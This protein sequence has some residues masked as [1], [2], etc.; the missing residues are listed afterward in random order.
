MALRD[1]AGLEA[2]IAGLV[3]DALSEACQPGLRRAVVLKATRLS[4]RTANPLV[5]LELVKAL[6]R[7]ERP[8]SLDE[9]QGLI[10]RLLAGR[11]RSY[12]VGRL[13]QG[14][15]AAAADRGG[16]P[17]LTPGE[18][19]RELGVSPKTVSNWCKQG[20]LACELLG[21]GHRRIPASALDAYRAS[22]ARWQQV[23]AARGAGPSPNDEA[24]FAELTARRR[25]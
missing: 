16:G 4:R 19:A 10:D 17:M 2:V 18:V 15:Q 9:L 8:A 20:L 12:S 11:R 22:Q 25:G 13:L 7:G 3:D 23:D 24:V 6:R 21:S 1:S 5:Q 14:N